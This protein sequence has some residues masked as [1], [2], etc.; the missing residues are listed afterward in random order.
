M[1]M[2]HLLLLCLAVI[3]SKGQERVPMRDSAT[4]SPA[5]AQHAWLPKRNSG[6]PRTS[7]TTKDWDTL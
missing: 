7:L 1:A 3:E 6:R 5:G 2:T 4:S